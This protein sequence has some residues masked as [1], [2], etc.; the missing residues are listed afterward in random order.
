[1]VPAKG[2]RRPVLSVAFIDIL[3]RMY[4]LNQLDEKR[5][6]NVNKSEFYIV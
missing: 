6:Y 1:M 4:G 5:I 3:E 2:L